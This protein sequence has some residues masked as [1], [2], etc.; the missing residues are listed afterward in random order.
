MCP[1][2]TRQSFCRA[3]ASTRS[4]SASDA[5]IGFSISRWVFFASSG[6]ATCSCLSVGTTTETAS[7]ASPS[8]SMDANTRHENFSLISFAR[9]ALGS[10]MPANSAPGSVE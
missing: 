3:A 4:A 7:Q 8:S 6:S 1:T 10:K 9:A 5:Q 2:C